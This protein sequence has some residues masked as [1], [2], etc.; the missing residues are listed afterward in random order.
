[1]VVAFP[2]IFTYIFV[3]NFKMLGPVVPEKS[4]TEKMFTHTQPLLHYVR[5]GYRLF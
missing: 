5:Q 2:N 4:L 1:M 3:P